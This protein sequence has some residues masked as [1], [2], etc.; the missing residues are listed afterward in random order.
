MQQTIKKEFSYTGIGLH[1]GQDVSISCHP[2]PPN[3]GIVFKRID[4]PEEPEIKADVDNITSTNRC[5][6]I[7]NSEIE[8]NTIEHLLSVINILKIDNLLIKIDAQEP[9]VTDGSSK[10]FYDLFTTVG[11]KEQQV[12]KRI[13]QVKEPL[14]IKEGEQY[15]T[16]LPDQDFK[17]SYTFV[18]DHQA[19][20][21]QFFEYNDAE[22][23]YEDVVA[24]ARTFGFAHEVKQ[25]QQAG[26]ALGGSLDNA[27]LVDD[28][29]PINKL[30]FSDEFARHKVLDLIGDMMLAPEFKGH[31]IAVR[32]GHMLNSKLAKKLKT[33]FVGRN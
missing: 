22:D 15:L 13:Y 28:E 17:I 33:K 26:L 10:V 27:V 12:E 29:G 19:I 24:P 2:L 6:A 32:S 1:T 4:L 20:N 14:Y 8:I 23:N 3:Q 21:D 7:G 9:P 18:G 31:I 11:L 25:L 30:R 5:T 16:V